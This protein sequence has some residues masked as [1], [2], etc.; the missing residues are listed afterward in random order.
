VPN[1]YH[2]V[3]VTLARPDAVINIAGLYNEYGITLGDALTAWGTDDAAWRS[4]QNFTGGDCVVH[5]Q[6]VI[7]L[8]T[9]LRENRDEINSM[10]ITT[11][12]N[13][14]DIY[15]VELLPAEVLEHVISLAR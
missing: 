12:P 1:G 14:G 8:S 7:T 5:D 6:F 2:V 3:G 11:H 15:Q 13:I 10:F 9:T 4:I